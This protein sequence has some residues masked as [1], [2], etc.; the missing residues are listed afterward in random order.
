[1]KINRREALFL[2]PAC[3]ILLGQ[4]QRQ[5]NPGEGGPYDF[6]FLNGRVMDPESGR[7]ESLN[8]GVRGQEITAL[9]TDKIQGRREI[10]ATGLVVAPGFIDILSSVRPTREAHLGKITD[11]VTTC[12]G[13]H[14]GPVDVGKYQ[15][16]M[17]SSKP[18]VNYA[19]TVGHAW[20][21]ASS[22]GINIGSSGL[23]EVVGA[24]DPYK[25]ATSEQI[26]RMRVIAT[27]AIEQGAVGIGF[28]INYCPGSSYEEIFGLFEIAS[29]LCVPCHLHARYKGN[30][31]PHTMS[32]AVEEVVAVAA[33]T[34]AQAQ[35]AHLTSS[36]VGSTPLCMQLIEGASR[37]GIDLVTRFDDACGERLSGPQ[38]MA[39]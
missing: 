28:G 8:V 12:L 21:Y 9:T 25:P 11:G 27:Q 18:L 16:E 17:A 37:H 24:T 4:D 2:L 30:V 3:S 29:A 1:V 10:D 22:I 14:G 33:A 19:T 31:F 32:L 36:T 26:E 39:K 7:D 38:W 13:M 34:G 15:Q 35:L 20:S 23:R 6:V 5:R